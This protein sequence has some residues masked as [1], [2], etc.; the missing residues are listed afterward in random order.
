MAKKKDTS[1]LTEEQTKEASDICSRF[2]D[3]ISQSMEIDIDDQEKPE[4]LSTGMPTLDIIMGGG[5][6]LGGFIQLYGRP[7][8]VDKD[9]EFFNGEEWKKISEYKTG[10]KVLQY[11]VETEE[12]TLVEPKRYIKEPCDKMYHFE[13]KYGINQ[14]LSPEH[15][16]IMVSCKN[17][18]HEINTQDFVDKHNSTNGVRDKFITTFKYNGKGIDLTDAQIKV[19]C[20]VICDGSFNK[21]RNDNYCRFHIKKDRKKIE[22]RKIFNEANIDYKEHESAAEGFSDFYI[23]APR[24]EKEFT[25]YWYNCNAHQLQLICNNILQWDGS[26]TV[27]KKG[28]TRKSFNTSIKKSADFVQFAFASCGY[29]CGIYKDDRVGKEHKSKTDDKTYVYKTPLYKLSVVDN[30]LVGLSVSSQSAGKT[31][32]KEVVPEDGYKYCFQ[33]P[34]GALVLRRANNIFITRNCSKSSLAA[35]LIANFQKKTNNKAL[36]VY[37]DAE[38]SMTNARLK[39]LGCG[40]VSLYNK[41]TVEKVFDIIDKIAEFKKAN[42]DQANVPSILIWDSVPATLSEKEATIEDPKEAIGQRAKLL[43]LKLFQVKYNLKKYRITVVAINQNRDKIQMGMTPTDTQVRGMKQN[44][45]IPGGKALMYATDQLLYMHDKSELEEDKM[46]FSGKE[47]IIK[48]IK[49][50]AFSPNIECTTIFSYAGG[51]SSF[52]STFYTLTAEKMIQVGGAYYNMPGYENKFF[53]KNALKLYKSDEKFK[54]AFNELIRQYGVNVVTKYKK[55][56]EASHEDIDMD[57]EGIVAVNIMVDDKYKQKPEKEA[58]E[59]KEPESENDT[60]LDL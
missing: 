30:N 37:L 47:V 21:D 17:N 53:A 7:G 12:A 23:K 6:I 31:Q 20:A 18:I 15:D 51:F 27:D 9:T 28:V 52:W 16:M 56:E 35:K 5:A 38:T 14:T 1:L 32:I 60:E 57:E 39:Q 36:A 8:C 42:P 41:C 19:M 11:N 44:E 48:C 13:T 33:V 58:K 34:N 10:D 49:N 50:K 55:Q 45:Q 25:S 46:G 26:V 22:L 54:N 2:N 4:L 24:R 29:R 43:T 40:H 59:S 3:F